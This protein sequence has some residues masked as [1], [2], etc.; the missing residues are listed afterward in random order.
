M[1]Q[2]WSLKTSDTESNKKAENPS[3][4][5]SWQTAVRVNKTS[6]LKYLLAKIC[7]PL[8][9]TR[10]LILTDQTSGLFILLLKDIPQ[11][12][13]L[14]SFPE[15]SRWALGTSS[16]RVPELLLCPSL[17]KWDWSWSLHSST[18][19][20]SQLSWGAAHTNCSTSSCSFN[21]GFGAVE[22]HR[23]GKN[24]SQNPT[25][26]VITNWSLF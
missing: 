16:L 10:F 15:I 25:P 24:P 26:A 5:F 7:H 11:D 4:L 12:W 3:P 6:T 13:H 20:N 14:G 8:C 19:G 23:K 2:P 1:L 18:H 22:N 17:P 9:H 21:P